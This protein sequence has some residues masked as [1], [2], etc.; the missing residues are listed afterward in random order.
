[1]YSIVTQS[2]T[3][4]IE[5]PFLRSHMLG[6]N[7][8]QRWSCSKFGEESGIILF[9]SRYSEW[10]AWHVLLRPLGSHSEMEEPS[11]WVTTTGSS[12]W[13]SPASW[14]PSSGP[15]SISFKLEISSEYVEIG[16]YL[17]SPYKWMSGQT[18]L[19]IPGGR[20]DLHG[21]GDLPLL[22]R[23]HH[24]PSGVLLL[25]HESGD[26]GQSLLWCPRSCRGKLWQYSRKIERK[27]FQVFGLFNTITY[28]VGSYFVYDELNSTPPELQ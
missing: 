3:T 1:M 10:S 22:H 4:V 25:L 27:I 16:A 21:S 12:S 15:S 18:P 9:I 24:D 7:K 23:L 13:S 14:S 2:T 6:S 20:V 26:A 19:Q 5:T 8:E 17:Y 28:G 11:A